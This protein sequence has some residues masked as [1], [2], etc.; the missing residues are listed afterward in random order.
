MNASEKWFVVM[1]A[2][3]GLQMYCIGGHPKWFINNR[4]TSDSK[5]NIRSP[6]V[7][8]AMDELKPTP[9]NSYL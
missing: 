5:I 3:N 2:A 7:V 6:V 9:I 8:R 4:V 1:S